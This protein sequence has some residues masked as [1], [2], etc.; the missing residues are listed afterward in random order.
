VGRNTLI[1][2][3]M[4]V[5][6]LVDNLSICMEGEVKLILEKI[7]M[8]QLVEEFVQSVKPKVEEKLKE[9]TFDT[10]NRFYSVDIMKE[11]LVIQFNLKDNK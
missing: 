3:H 4:S 7:W 5:N 9:L 10:I 8:D 6:R 11:N 2:E 1:G